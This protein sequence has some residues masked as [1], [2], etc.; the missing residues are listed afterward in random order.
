MFGL[1]PLTSFWNA[2]PSEYPKALETGTATA[3]PICRYLHKTHIIKS[4]TWGFAWSGFKS[5]KK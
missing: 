1:F 5:K 4:I 2:I 3:F